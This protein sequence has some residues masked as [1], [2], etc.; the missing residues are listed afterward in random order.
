MQRSDAELLAATA[1]GDPDAFATFFRRHEAAVTRYA[2]RRSVSVEEVGDAVAEAF[3]V[4]LRQAG[5]YRDESGSASPWLLGITHRVLWQQARGQRR[6]KRLTAR[7]AAA[8]PSYGPDE[9]ERVIEALD[10]AGRL[11]PLR[12]AL[13]R[14]PARERDVLQLVALGDLS[15]SEAAQSLGISANAARTRLAR[16][17]RRLEADDVP[18]SQT[19]VTCARST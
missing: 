7:V 11:D 18:V 10:A 15:P 5:R 6:R 13:E 8:S 16:A 1:D 4:A 17:R 14:L 2:V 9:Q 19:E 3:L 12:P